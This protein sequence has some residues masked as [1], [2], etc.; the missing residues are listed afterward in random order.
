MDAK[1]LS[2]KD[3]AKLLG[4]EESVL[5]RCMRKGTIMAPAL[6]I[7]S[8]SHAATRL[9]TTD[10]IERARKVLKYYP[11]PKPAAIQ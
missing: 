11:K 9:W 2:T 3:A 7:D 8:N 5:R 1:L 6:G 4:V 10:D